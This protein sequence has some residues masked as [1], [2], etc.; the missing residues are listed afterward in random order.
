[1]SLTSEALRTRLRELEAAA[2]NTGAAVIA[3]EDAHAAAIKR[4]VETGD[5]DTAEQTDA[6]L[7]ATS[8][9]HERTA[10]MVEQARQSLAEAVR[11]EK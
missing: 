4:A 3:A 8:R 6:V 10:A 2:E 7:R 5:S 1:M 11:R 9:E